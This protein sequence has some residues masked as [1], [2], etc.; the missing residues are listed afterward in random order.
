MR[1][2]NQSISKYADSEG[3]YGFEDMRGDKN[4]TGAIEL[5]VRSDE[6]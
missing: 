5:A 4:G 6:A 2:R 3:A 1:N